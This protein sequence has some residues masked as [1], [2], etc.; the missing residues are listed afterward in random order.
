MISYTEFISNYIINIPSLQRDYIQGSNKDPKNVKKRD[1]FIKFLIDSLKNG[2]PIDLEFIYGSSKKSK[3]IHEIQTADGII[4]EKEEEKTYFIPIDGQQRLTTLALLG[5]LLSRMTGYPNPD[6]LIKLKEMRYSVRTSTQ[7]F[8]NNLL[9]TNMPVIDADVTSISEWIKKVAEWFVKKWEYDPSIM[10]MLDLLDE[11]YQRLSE[12]KSFL[13]AMSKNFFTENII[14]FEELDMDKY[15]LDEDLYV[16]MNARGKHLTDFE[17]WKAEFYGFLKQHYGIHVAKFFSN[18]IEGKWCDFFWNF[19]IKDWKSKDEKTR[20]EEYPRI[21]ELF[22]NVYYLVTKSLFLANNNIKD[23]ADQ[24]NVENNE[25]YKK[26]IDK[27]PFIVY[28]TWE[29]VR[30]LFAFFEIIIL[31][32]EKEGSIDNWLQKQFCNY[33]TAKEFD[34]QDKRVNIYESPEFFNILIHEGDEKLNLRWVLL[35][36][37]LMYR[38][39]NLQYKYKKKKYSLD[40]VK[41]IT[42]GIEYARIIW[43]WE[44]NKNWREAKNL[45]YAYAI[46]V[47]HFKDVKELSTLLLS[48]DDIFK[49]LEKSKFEEEKRKADYIPE[50]KYDAVKVLSNHPYLKGNLDN[51]YDSLD[52]LSSNE[53][54]ERFITFT[55]KETFEKI[56][57]LTIHGF[58]GSHPYNQ[59][60][61]FYGW[62]G[63]WAYV[64]TDQDDLFKK[65]INDILQEKSDSSDSGIFNEYMLKYFISYE[66]FYFYLDNS[67]E[68]KG[69]GLTFGGDI[70][71]S[72]LASYYS[73]PYS[74]S[75]IKLYLKKVPENPSQVEVGWGRYTDSYGYINIKGVG[76]KMRCRKDG[77]E[78]WIDNKESWEKYPNKES[79]K[80]YL[81]SEHE[82]SA[83]LPEELDRVE[84][85]VWFLEQIK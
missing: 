50:G 19:A 55:R 73:D 1:R 9:T 36:M 38:T 22:M 27:S 85:A 78:I 31:I 57:Q 32:S 53:I 71:K 67:Y 18:R 44:L 41:D 65:A 23:L 33:N 2:K 42:G 74:Y 84:Q 46:R 76:L 14:S 80:P 39:I 52:I 13:P 20:E 79:I 25:V 68:V 35:V 40:P 16:K 82:V 5:W 43:D 58:K 72:P 70:P 47:E 11:L 8:V 75:A 48:E 12:E 83:S 6:N 28:E 77:W 45:R 81:T 54:I 7:A 15:E 4:E 51:I 10:A 59:F 64:F 62:G 60:F 37:S 30:G 3:E 29:N 66:Y 49:G 21:D 63:H 24:L 56:R 17:N 69:F 34:P 26:V 61:R